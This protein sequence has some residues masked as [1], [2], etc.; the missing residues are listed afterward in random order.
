MKRTRVGRNPIKPSENL[1][2][3]M[4]RPSEAQANNTLPA[5]GPQ[6][7]SALCGGWQCRG[8]RG[9]TDSL[10]QWGTARPRGHR[11]PG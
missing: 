1:A 7:T 5:R 10:V 3:P 8:W 11:H 9:L 4:R 6:A 2:K